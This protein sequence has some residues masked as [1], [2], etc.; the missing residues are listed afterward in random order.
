MLAEINT[1]AELIPIHTTRP[2]KLVCIDF[3]SLERTKSSYEN[4]LVNQPFLKTIANALWK[5][6]IV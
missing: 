5:S 3:L 2:L 1:V 6:F 4:I